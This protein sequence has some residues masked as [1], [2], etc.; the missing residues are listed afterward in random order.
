FA[1]YVGVGD[2]S[3]IKERIEGFR[4]ANPLI[5]LGVQLDSA[6]NVYTV[7]LAYHGQ[8]I[9]VALREGGVLVT[10]VRETIERFDGARGTGVGPRMTGLLGSLGDDTAAV[11]H[12]EPGLVLEAMVVSTIDRVMGA[13]VPGDHP[14]RAEFVALRD[15]LWTTM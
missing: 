15:S 6:T 4:A 1:V 7:A 14:A 11:L 2:V 5:A 9:Y 10:S 3:A 13:K 12:V 8:P